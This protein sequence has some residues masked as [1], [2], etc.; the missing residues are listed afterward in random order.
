[1]K[2]DWRS[3]TGLW[4]LTI[5]G[6]VAGTL[7]LVSALAESTSAPQQAAGAAVAVAFV[8]L[9]Y[10][11][12]RAAE[13]IRSERERND[14]PFRV[15]N[16]K[17]CPEC[18]ESVQDE[19]LRRHPLD[20]GNLN[21]GDDAQVPLRAKRSRRDRAHTNSALPNWHHLLQSSSFNLPLDRFRW[22]VYDLI[23][24]KQTTHFGIRPQGAELNRA[25]C[26]DP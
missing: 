20:S 2:V 7:T 6:V 3:T 15:F 9:P 13:G 8:A 4:W 17:K 10:C 14:K 5:I 24:M 16:T 18:A 11:F 1:M 21:Q 12:A 22:L 23:S 19:A 25:T 26:V